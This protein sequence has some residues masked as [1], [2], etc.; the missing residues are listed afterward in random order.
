MSEYLVL[1]E[2]ITYKNNKLSCMNIYDTISTVVLP[3]EFKFDIA[4]MCG[5]DWTAGEHRLAVKAIASNGR[6]VSIGMIDINIPNE[7]FVYNAIARDITM[8]LD[9]TVSEMTFVVY[10]GEKKVISRKYNVTSMFI[11]QIAGNSTTPEETQA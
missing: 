8:F 7:S 2:N 9:H 10:D 11:P 3:A 4:I 5:P 6:E 1:A